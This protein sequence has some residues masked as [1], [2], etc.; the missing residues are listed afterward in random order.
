MNGVHMA[1]KG[2]LV[3]E[4]GQALLALIRKIL[5]MNPDVLR[6]LGLLEKA[7]GAHSAPVLGKGKAGPI[8]DVSRQRGCVLKLFQ[9]VWTLVGSIVDASMLRQTGASFKR[10]W[11]VAAPVGTT[12]VQGGNHGTRQL[13]SGSFGSKW[14][15][16][17]AT[18]GRLL[19]W[20]FA[21]CV[22][23][24]DLIVIIYTAITRV[25]PRKLFS[26]ISITVAFVRF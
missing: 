17:A 13:S 26:L 25:G 3:F 4:L 24:R 18:H 22:R 10:F 20:P 16:S 23:G 15:R 1:A 9:T 14:Y 21:G 12:R 11:T 5:C 7:L 8:A 6:P 2:R 19:Q